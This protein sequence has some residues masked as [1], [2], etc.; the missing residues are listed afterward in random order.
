[1]ALVKVGFYSPSLPVAG[2][3]EKY[4]LTIVEEAARRPQDDVILMSPSRP[5]PDDWHRIGISVAPESFTWRRTRD[6]T[7]MAGTRSLDLFVCM[8]PMLPFSHAD[9]SVALVQF[10]QRDLLSKQRSSSIRGLARAVRNAILH[11]AV[12]SYQLVVCY[13]EFARRYTE[14]YLGRPDAVVIYPPVNAAVG[15]SRKE[16]ML[17]GVARFF[18][19]KRQDVLID[20]FRRMR[21]RLPK[22]SPWTLHLAGGLGDDTASRKY[23]TDLRRLARGLPVVFHPNVPLAELRGLYQRAAVFWHA[24]G[25]G[26]E[27][28]PVRQEHFGITT[29]EAMNHGCVPVVIALGGQ[30]EIVADG[31]NG[32]LWRSADELV[33]STLELISSAAR[34][35]T[36]ARAAAT[37]G[38]RFMVDHFRQQV[39]DLILKPGGHRCVRVGSRSAR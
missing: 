29:V 39:R 4:L 24:A 22:D 19:M 18:E 30:L 10:P 32:L 12:S 23:M 13:S 17:L 28:I 16:P 36:L 38:E 2:G 25:V 11:S 26:S 6:S 5:R 3:G 15:T 21:R 1:M 20:A 7:V 33:T 31:V 14:A 35:E 9:R 27:Y 37:G 34:R 8:R